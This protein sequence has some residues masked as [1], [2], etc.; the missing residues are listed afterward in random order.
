MIQTQYIVQAQMIPT[1]KKCDLGKTCA[2]AVFNF[3]L[4]AL[5]S[6][7]YRC[8]DA[9]DIYIRLIQWAHWLLNIGNDLCTNA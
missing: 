1:V 9:A 3:K 6:M 7:S 5:M 2:R 4:F 8:I